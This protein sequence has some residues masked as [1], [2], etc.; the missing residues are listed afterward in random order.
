MKKQPQWINTD[1]LRIPK[2]QITNYFIHLCGILAW[3]ILI[4]LSFFSW[5][6]MQHWVVAVLINQT[7]HSCKRQK[8]GQII[9]YHWWLVDVLSN[10]PTR[11]KSSRPMPTTK[12]ITVWENQLQDGFLY[13][14]VQLVWQCL[15]YFICFTKVL[16]SR[17]YN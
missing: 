8:F 4:Y 16:I 7:L 6:N 11:G 9:T 1:Q 15:C 12:S 13:I 3:P 17:Q 14:N 10:I 5:L 2:L